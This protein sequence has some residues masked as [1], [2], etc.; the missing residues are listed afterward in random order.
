MVS[1]YHDEPLS[2]TQSGHR[3]TAL[4]SLR[5]RTI[6]LLTPLD[7]QTEIII[8]KLLPT[9]LLMCVLACERRSCIRVFSQ[10]KSATRILID[11]LLCTGVPGQQKSAFMAEMDR[12]LLNWGRRNTTLVG[13]ILVIKSLALSKLVHFFIALPTP[14]KDFFR[15][16]NKKFYR[17]LWKGK[18]PKIKKT[19]LELDI[20]DGGLK[21]VNVETF[22]K[23]LKTK[24]LKTV[25]TSNEIW[26]LIPKS[27]KI[28]KVG[29]YGTKFYKEILTLLKNPFWISM[30]RA[31]ASFHQLFS[32]KKHYGTY[33]EFSHMV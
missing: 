30:V 10:L 29:N 12:I 33:N 27:H 9:Q 24:W 7:Q 19:T 4:L 17:F 15:E 13:R 16:I 3:R 8:Q 32:E 6:W 31:L 21:M 14:P 22:E 2:V 1:P 23:T 20:K 25:L 26:A 18:P 28:D 11:S 5:K